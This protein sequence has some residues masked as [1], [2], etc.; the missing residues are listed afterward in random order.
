MQHGRKK[1]PITQKE[2]LALPDSSAEA[3]MAE[4]K[5]ALEAQIQQAQTEALLAGAQ[6]VAEPSSTEEERA[7]WGECWG[8]SRVQCAKG[9][10]LDI[11]IHRCR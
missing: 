3:K 6:H 8:V 4:A 11:L 9:L 5:A 2:I 10:L 1:N 7:N